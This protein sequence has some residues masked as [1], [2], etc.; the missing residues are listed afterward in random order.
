[1]T[2]VNLHFCPPSRQIW[3][4]II[5]IIDGLMLLSTIPAIYYF[6]KA[7]LQVKINHINTKTKT[8]ESRFLFYAALLF[9]IITF[10][11]L[12]FNLLAGVYK[13]STN[14]QHIY[15][16]FEPPVIIC[17][18]MQFYLLLLLSFI[19][20]HNVFSTTMYQLSHITVVIFIITYILLPPLIITA[21]LLQV[22]SLPGGFIM[23]MMAFSIFII[24]IITLMVIYIRKLLKVYRSVIDHSDTAD[25]DSLLV[26]IT[27]TTILTLFSLLVTFITPIVFILMTIMKSQAYIGNVVTS[28]LL[29][30]IYT[31][32]L[33]VT[34]SCKCFAKQ[35]MKMC[36]C[37]HRICKQMW[38]IVARNKTEG[39]IV[40][41]MQINAASSTAL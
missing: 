15:Y 16:A 22:F 13:C 7:Y 23:T 26:I 21:A 41:E 32:F 25:T 28:T 10:I 19:R 6:I 29:L 24:L 11:V 36:G 35:Y 30:D 14:H 9:M 12:L 34:L 40:S 8:K 27:K 37:V 39:K 17:Y 4:I 38:Y 1:M 31:N 18:G 3:L 2:P 33:C 20:L 5:N